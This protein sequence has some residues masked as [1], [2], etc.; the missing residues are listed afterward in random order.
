M[1]VPTT[2]SIYYFF[3]SFTTMLNHLWFTL[4]SISCELPRC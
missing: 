2:S 1:D 3:R 4:R